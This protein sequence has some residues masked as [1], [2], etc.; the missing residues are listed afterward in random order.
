[1]NMSEAEA[2]SAYDLTVKAFTPD[3]NLSMDL[4]Q[5]MVADQIEALKPEKT[6]KAADMF[7]FQ[8]LK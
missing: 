3:G 8:F 1:M 7:D 6:P 4:Q 2:K 5:K